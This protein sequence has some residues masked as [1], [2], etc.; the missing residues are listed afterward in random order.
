VWPR[1]W[2]TG[3]EWWIGEVVIAGAEA[4]DSYTAIVGQSQCPTC[5]EQ[6]PFLGAHASRGRL[7]AWSGTI[8]GFGGTLHVLTWRGCPDVD[9]RFR[10]WR[11]SIPGLAARLVMP[12][13]R[14][15]LSLTSQTATPASS[16]SKLCLNP[17]SHGQLSFLI[18][19]VLRGRSLTLCFPSPPPVS[20]KIDPGNLQLGLA[21]SIDYVNIVAGWDRNPL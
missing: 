18:E 16:S 4:A 8:F 10:A 2:F 7:A 17:K 3:W 14:R 19:T 6:N 13:V 1:H 21:Q 15:Y 5:R 12:A 9:R 11:I 20:P